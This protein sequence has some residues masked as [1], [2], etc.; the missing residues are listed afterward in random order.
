[1]K[2]SF[3]IACVAAMFV[4]AV[5]AAQAQTCTTPEATLTSPAD[6]SILQP[7]PV[8]TFYNFTW[9]NA[10]GD[11]F[12]IVESIPG[13]HDIFFAFTG[14]AGGGAGQ[15]FLNLVSTCTT[16]TLGCILPL[17]E[18]IYFTLDTVK[19]K[20]IIGSHQY[21]FTAPSTPGKLATTTS[22]GTAS[23]SSSSA[24][25]NITLTASVSATSSVN[26]GTVTFQV[27][28]GATKVGAAVTSTT[29]TACGASL[30]SGTKKIV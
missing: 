27:L 19:A 3:V 10:S 23:A 18:H 15:N 20:Q 24:D 5:T 28:D 13:A 12:V 14:G 8:T 4:L 30:D 7:D 22:V 21:N 25:Q 11:Y 16:P 17:G 6:N 9:C 29:L 1:M 26:Q 2:R